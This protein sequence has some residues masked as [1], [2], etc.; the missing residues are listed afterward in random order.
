[1]TAE[2]LLAYFNRQSGNGLLEKEQHSNVVQPL[3][4]QNNMFDNKPIRELR[5]V[6]FERKK[7][8]VCF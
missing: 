3:K 2:E 7:W 4:V 1:M 8:N 6:I 5:T